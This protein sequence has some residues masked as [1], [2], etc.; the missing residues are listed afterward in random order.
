MMTYEVNLLCDSCERDCVTGAPSDKLEECI[1]SAI[2]M[3]RGIAWEVELSPD[4]T[5][6]ARCANCALRPPPAP[7]TL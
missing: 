5:I 6:Y 1:Q 2:E 3:A 7:K 4:G